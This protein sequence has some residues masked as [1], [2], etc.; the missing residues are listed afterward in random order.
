MKHF[1]EREA[2]L[3]AAFSIIMCREL[4]TAVIVADCKCQSIYFNTGKG[5]CL[6]K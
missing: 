5:I 1:N 2:I 4:E 3:V 6:Q